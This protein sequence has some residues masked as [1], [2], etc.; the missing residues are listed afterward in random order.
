[1]TSLIRSEFIKLTSTR[2]FLA[3]MTGAVAVVLLG[4]VSTIMSSDSHSLSGPLREQT[5]YVLASINSGL[6]ALV[7]GIRIFTDE[8]RHGTVIATLL[9]GGRAVRVLLAK[10]SVA[11]AA[12]AV[13][14]VAAAV[15]MSVAAVVLSSARGPGFDIGSSDVSALAGMAA[16]LALW[17]V[18]GA[19]LGAIVRHQVAAIV[20]GLIWVLVVENLGASLLRN[21]GIY[22][23]GQAAHG[24]AN[25]S[26]ES[27]AVPT[28][29]AV[30]GTY[31]IMTLLVAAAALTR[32]DVV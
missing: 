20:G 18:I 4:T 31:S 11:A 22:L 16:A 19:A 1:M 7:L 2:T 27:L 24:L 32:R 26:V 17:A 15:A 5:F 21:A 30:L 8:F 3:L 29:A 6:F 10:I 12:A 9:A 23:P 13:M 28:A 25:A 14:S